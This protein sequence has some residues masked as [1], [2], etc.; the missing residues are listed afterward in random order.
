MP[1]DGPSMYLAAALSVSRRDCHATGQ[2]S[3]E[4]MVL[5]TV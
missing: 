3:A 4:L 2:I 5:K 1:P